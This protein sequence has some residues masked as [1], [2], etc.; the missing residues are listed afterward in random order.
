MGADGGIYYISYTPAT[1]KTKLLEMLKEWLCSDGCPYDFDGF[2]EVNDGK[3][4][5]SQE[6]EDI[7]DVKAIPLFTEE[8]LNF[9]TKIQDAVVEHFTFN[10]SIP[11]EH[12]DKIMTWEE[13]YFN[14]KYDFNFDFRDDFHELLSITRD[15]NEVWDAG[16]LWMYWDTS[17]YHYS[18]PFSGGDGE[19]KLKQ[20][21]KSCT[22][23]DIFK[24]IFTDFKQFYDFVYMLPGVN[25]I[26]VWT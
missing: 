6:E 26:Q 4:M 21:Y 24:Q 22:T 8:Q 9:I 17:S 10:Q 2:I 14:Q 15:I 16:W 25:Y 1:L 12:S 7:P 18:E 3:I 19:N 11:S 20:M 13:F 23:N 5:I